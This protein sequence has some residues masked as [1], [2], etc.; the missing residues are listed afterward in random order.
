MRLFIS[1]RHDDAP[2]PTLQLLYAIEA[3][4]RPEEIFFDEN[5]LTLGLDWQRNLEEAVSSCDAV[6]AVIGPRWLELL[7]VKA[8][9]GGPDFLK[10]ELEIALKR[11]IPVIP[12]Y[13]DETPFLEREQLP[14]T[15]ADLAGRQGRRLRGV[16]H[17][18]SDLGEIARRTEMAVAAG[19]ASPP[20]HEPEPEPAPE[21]EALA[22]PVASTPM[23]SVATSSP[24][25]DGVEGAAAAGDDGRE[26]ECLRL[27]EAALKEAEVAGDEAE[28]V[29]AGTAHA[30][31]LIEFARLSA[32]ADLASAIVERAEANLDADDPDAVRAAGVRL[33]AE[34]PL[35]PMLFRPQPD[36]RPVAERC[37]L[38]LGADDPTTLLVSLE[39][40]LEEIGER[41]LDVGLPGGEIVISEARIAHGRGSATTLRLALLWGN[42]VYAA[43]ALDQ[44]DASLEAAVRQLRRPVADGAAELGD[45]HHLVVRGRGLITL[46]ESFTEDS[47][48]DPQGV[49]AAA[50]DLL[51][52]GH[53]TTLALLRVNRFRLSH[54][55]RVGPALEVARRVWTVTERRLGAS[56]PATS[57]AAS[58]LAENASNAEEYAEAVRMDEV[59]LAERE[60]LLGPGHAETAQASYS[61]VYDLERL[62]APQ[63]ERAAEVI[64]E[65]WRHAPDDDG[66]D[67]PWGWTKVAIRVA[68]ELLQRDRF[69]EAKAVA[70][71]GARSALALWGPE[72]I[73][74]T[75]ARQRLARALFFL[76]EDAAA[77]EIAEEEWER[78]VR[79][80]RINEDAIWAAFILVWVRYGR[81]HYEA[82]VEIA[83]QAGELAER[84]LP[85]GNPATVSLLTHGCRARAMLGDATLA[86][87]LNAWEHIEASGHVTS[88]DTAVIR[89]MLLSGELAEKCKELEQNAWAASR[90]EEDDLAIV[91]RIAAMFDSSQPIQSAALALAWSKV[92]AL[93]QV[94]Y[95]E[96]E[97]AKFAERIAADLGSWDDDAVLYAAP[98]AS[99]LLE[100]RSMTAEAV[101]LCERW[102]AL[103]E[104]GGQDD[105]WPRTTLARM[106]R[107]HGGSDRAI[108]LL[109][110]AFTEHTGGSPWET[111]W[112]IDGIL[113]TDTPRYV[114]RLLAHA[115]LDRDAPGDDERAVAFFA[116]LA[117][118]YDR[119][120]DNVGSWKIGG[121]QDPLSFQQG[122]RLVNYDHLIR[123]VW[124]ETRGTDRDR[125]PDRG[126]EPRS[127]PAPYSTFADNLLKRWREVNPT[128]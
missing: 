5:S 70:E 107:Y 52:I 51:G 49:I 102:V 48:E 10:F 78:S 21:P 4:L 117:Y 7:E 122:D 56:D 60:R 99:A 75:L 127:L 105:L 17:R 32:A 39:A 46:F 112:K 65:R 83:D 95:K 27:G 34:T 64:L 84:A 74:T 94:G 73:H 108:D 76:D 82:A 87:V 123:E 125:M 104:A 13:V 128:G 8:Q 6:L 119:A 124:K 69:E 45:E 58:L 54:L 120:W 12:V 72:D 41:G 16:P 93:L 36:A 28:I 44:L 15:I 38:V 111:D 79:T 106:L 53:P 3:K 98:F 22:E 1:W 18:H 101:G 29:R 23:A 97:A 66:T 71:R 96:E 109:T 92:G 88:S 77:E 91:E 55:Q 90:L 11:E 25:T 126:A 61:L 115:C 62:P 24:P 2:D 26:V 85:K 14:E 57:S 110:S 86:G 80:N 33:V 31:W 59:V 35:A 121:T 37:R 47:E 30:F 89:L 20:R 9:S 67:L 68:I 81:A 40:A 63:T 42:G 113:A 118:R 114:G 116:R 103:L 19:R 43:T 50:A 100:R